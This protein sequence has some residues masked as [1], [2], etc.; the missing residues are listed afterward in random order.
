[1][2][3][4]KIS[5]FIFVTLVAFWFYNFR[6]VEFIP[7][8]FNRIDDP[9]YGV[10]IERKEWSTPK[11]LECFKQKLRIHHH[12][13]IEKDGRLYIRAYLAKEE[14][15]IYLN[16]WDNGENCMERGGGEGR[17]GFFQDIVSSN[18]LG[19]FLDKLI[20]WKWN[21]PKKKD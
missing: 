18:W 2:N 12:D 14:S 16:W 17:Y 8:Q 11:R 6:W 3:K 5:I 21:E 4:K 1:M 19:T 20:M 9:N 13:W 15:T 7:H 10:W